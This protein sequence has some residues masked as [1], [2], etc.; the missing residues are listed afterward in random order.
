MRTKPS[1]IARAII[2]AVTI[3]FIGMGIAVPLV[4]VAA[5]AP[6]PQLTC[7]VTMAD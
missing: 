4:T 2:A 5:P 6:K 3:G 1:L 7:T